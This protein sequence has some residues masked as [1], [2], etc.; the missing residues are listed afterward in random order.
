MEPSLD[1]PGVS[2]DCL[3]PPPHL[4]FQLRLEVL[5]NPPDHHHQCRGWMITHTSLF[6]QNV[7]RWKRKLAHIPTCGQQSELNY[8]QA[9]YHLSL[10][11]RVM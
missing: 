1:P 3:A 9:P 4:Q 7:C 5:G 10:R 11:L 8:D 2:F 6:P